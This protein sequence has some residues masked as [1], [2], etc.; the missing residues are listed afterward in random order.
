M[1]TLEKNYSRSI[2]TRYT[3]VLSAQNELKNPNA[4]HEKPSGLNK[5][6]SFSSS[7]VPEE[8]RRRKFYVFSVKKCE[9]FVTE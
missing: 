2:P 7:V 4:F 8:E 9:H 6:I 1:E 5:T 3:A